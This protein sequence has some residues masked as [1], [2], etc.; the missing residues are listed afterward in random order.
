MWLVAGQQHRLVRSPKLEMWVANVRPDLFNDAELAEIRAQPSRLLPGDELLDL[1]RLMSQVAQDS[2]DPETYNSGIS[3]AMRRA[4]RASHDCAPADIKLM[5]PAV[6]RALML[7]R[8]SG[9]SFSLSRLAEES[10]IAPSYLSRLLIEHT[11]CSFVDWRNRIRL[12]RFFEHYRPGSNLLEAS[13]VA[14]FGSYARFLHIF[15]ELVGCTPSEWAHRADRA[16]PPIEV[17]YEGA[18]NANSL[19]P[20]SNLRIR[21]RWM[22][23]VPVA[24]PVLRDFF[25][26]NFLDD[27]LAAKPVTRYAAKSQ[28]QD[29]PAAMSA[30]DTQCFVQA[31]ATE[32]SESGD[33]FSQVLRVHDFG[34]LFSGVLRAYE[35]DPRKLADAATAFIVLLWTAI[36]GTPDPS[37]DEVHASRRQITNVLRCRAAGNDEKNRQIHV[38]LLC[39]FVVVYQALQAARASGND[40]TLAQLRDAATHLAKQ[41]FGE[42]IA[43]AKLTNEGFQRGT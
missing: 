36:D 15:T 35:L 1:D 28:E 20:T 2:D 30:I 8:Q 37:S 22:R 21:R 17:T 23:L 29:L 33:E 31:M 39:H 25:G 19:L 32:S 38:A 11:N 6:T 14:G 40:R 4:L 10:G 26:K 13:V 7:L 42:S 18:G 24:N 34:S 3:Y 43:S 16:I 12:E 5:H 41:I 27:V 9:G